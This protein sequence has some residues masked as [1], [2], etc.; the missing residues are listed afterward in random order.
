MSNVFNQRWEKAWGYELSASMEFSFGISL[1][2]ISFDAKLSFS[3]KV[4]YSGSVGTERTETNEVQFGDEQTFSCPPRSRCHLNLVGT[5]LDNV[6]VPF[7]ATV[8]RNQCCQ[9]LSEPSGQSSQKVRPIFE[10]VRP[11]LWPF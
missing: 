11:L 4:S 7:I 3:A 8:Q 2:P 6:A 1:S 5:K 10:K 9:V